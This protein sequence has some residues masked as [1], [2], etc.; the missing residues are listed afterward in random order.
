MLESNTLSQDC[1]KTKQNNLGK[2]IP[3]PYSKEAV[4]TVIQDLSGF[5]IFSIG[6]C[7]SPKLR[8]SQH[9]RE[10]G[11]PGGSVVKNL[12]VNTGVTDSI[13]GPGG[14]HMLQSNSA[15]A[16][17]PLKPLLL[18]EDLA[19]SHPRP[20]LG[21]EHLFGQVVLQGKVLLRMS[22]CT[23]KPVLHSEKP[24]HCRKKPRGNK[25]PAQPKIKKTF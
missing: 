16:P 3:I 4:D 25:D 6:L 9:S 5:E 2:D 7:P 14:S 13:P 21:W 12:P 17:Q 15:R 24:E 11:F 22:L 18:G 19:R 20:L 10:G 1:P 8:A 23:Q